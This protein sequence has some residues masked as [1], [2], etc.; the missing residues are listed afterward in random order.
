MVIQGKK[1]NV[2]RYVHAYPWVFDMQDSLSLSS[3]RTEERN[4]PCYP[5]TSLPRPSSD[6][7][8]AL[9]VLTLDTHVPAS[10]PATAFEGQPNAA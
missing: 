10:Y 6:D 4:V 1:K 8:R 2:G 7:L 5:L 3:D 9:Q